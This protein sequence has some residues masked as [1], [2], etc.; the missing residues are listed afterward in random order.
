MPQILIIG[1]GNSLRQDDTVGWLA[2]QRLSSVYENDDSV[3]VISCRQL[4]PELAASV[5]D[6]D[7]VLFLDA[8][9][10]GAPGE[11]RQQE[12]V[13]S[14]AGHQNSTHRLTPQELL[15]TSVHLYEKSPR[16]L[17]LSVTGRQFDLGEDL[18]EEATHGLDVLV[19]RARSIVDGLL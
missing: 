9:C 19:E 11:L 8:A 3:A 15:A 18:S 2:G 14:H 6:A 16:C 12:V 1:Y 5:A 17:L 13:Q 7:L 10:D 4:T